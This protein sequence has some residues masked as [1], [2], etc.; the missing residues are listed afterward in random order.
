MEIIA[1]GTRVVLMGEILCGDDCGNTYIAIRER[2]NCRF[3]QSMYNADFVSFDIYH[4][5]EVN[6][7]LG[8]QIFLS[9]RRPGRSQNV[10][11]YEDP[12]FFVKFEPIWL[13]RERLAG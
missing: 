11:M 8:G 3:S 9:S 13:G 2:S 10:T 5:R 4:P 7:G 12:Q 6:M 1:G